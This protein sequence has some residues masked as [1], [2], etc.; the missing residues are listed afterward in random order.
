MSDATISEI[1]AV[2]IECRELLSDASG[3][4][5]LSGE[6]AP[7]RD[8]AKIR[9]NIITVNNYLLWAEDEIAKLRPCER[10]R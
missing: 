6:T 9:R 3:S 1:I 7:E 8:K 4:A 5:L 2:L 10:R